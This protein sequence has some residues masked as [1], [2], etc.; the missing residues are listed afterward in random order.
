MLPECIREN[1]PLNRVTLYK[2]PFM[3]NSPRTCSI[4]S[5]LWFSK[6]SNRPG[7]RCFDSGILQLADSEKSLSATFVSFHHLSNAGRRCCRAGCL[8]KS[9]S[10]LTVEPGRGQNLTAVVEEFTSSFLSNYISF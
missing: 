4:F 8:P 2:L 1:Y 5:D 9:Q 10:N 6:N 3:N 7:V